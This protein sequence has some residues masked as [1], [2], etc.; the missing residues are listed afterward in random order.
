MIKN[1]STAA[2]SPMK[3]S[4]AK[5]TSASVALLLHDLLP[6]LLLALLFA[7]SLL[8]LRLFMFSQRERTRSSKSGL[9]LWP[10]RT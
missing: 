5:A 10:S 2:K 4:A 9:V 3:T 7:A 1:S 8:L 6:L